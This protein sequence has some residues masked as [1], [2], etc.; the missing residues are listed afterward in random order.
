MAA[1]D[2]DDLISV[3]DAG[4][5]GISALVADAESGRTRIILRHNKP[6]AAVVG[7][8]R[9]RRMDEVEEDLVLLVATVSRLIT[10]NGKRHSIEDVAAEFGVDLD[11]LAD[12]G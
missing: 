10:D 8:D 9:L 7:L 6:A 3:T 12:E 11:E 4:N 2:T 1:I 5:M